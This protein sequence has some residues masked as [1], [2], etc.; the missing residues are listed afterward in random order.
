MN[1]ASVESSGAQQQLPGGK[2]EGAAEKEGTAG[3]RPKT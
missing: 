2:G 3:Q 1:N